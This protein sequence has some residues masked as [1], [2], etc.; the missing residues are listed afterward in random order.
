MTWFIFLLKNPPGK[1]YE[2]H[3]DAAG[4]CR[5]CAMYFV[6][7]FFFL[8]ALLCTV[9][10]TEWVEQRPDSLNSGYLLTLSGGSGLCCAA[11]L[12]VFLWLRPKQSTETTPLLA[13]AV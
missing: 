4:E 2:R 12:A 10:I 9:A 3:F 6:V 8:S 5:G 11:F 1:M 7:V 13:T